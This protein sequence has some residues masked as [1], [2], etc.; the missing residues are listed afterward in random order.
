MATHINL[1]KWFA[2]TNV[3][4]AWNQ[5]IYSVLFGMANDLLPATAFKSP[6]IALAGVVDYEMYT[7]GV[8]FMSFFA[9]NNLTWPAE[10]AL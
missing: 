1:S 10:R 6:A 5:T 2:L 9:R 3:D 7:A 8:T 4:A